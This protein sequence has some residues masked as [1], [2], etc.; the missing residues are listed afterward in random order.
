[1]LWS[2]AAIA[3]DATLKRDYRVRTS[4]RNDL[5]GIAILRQETNHICLSKQYIA[6]KTTNNNN[7]NNN[8]NKNNNNRAAAATVIYR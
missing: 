4:G 6:V 5:S 7:S 2:D 3:C 8:N 1:M